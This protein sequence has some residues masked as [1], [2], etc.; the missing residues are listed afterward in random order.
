MKINKVFENRDGKDILLDAMI[1]YEEVCGFI[2]DFINFEGLVTDGTIQN[3]VY[4][5]YERDVEKVG[6][7]ILI[8]SFGDWEERKLGV[9][10]IMI[11]NETEKKLH[12]FI[13][14]P[15]LYKSTKNYNI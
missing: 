15:S 1:E 8:V 3:V 10:S 9:P 13:E 4:Y 12:R 14:N 2:K 11:D 7:I 6:D 5:Y